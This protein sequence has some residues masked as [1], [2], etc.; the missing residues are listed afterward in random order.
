MCSA[1]DDACTSIIYFLHVATHSSPIHRSVIC[2]YCRSTGTLALV[3]PNHASLYT[4]DTKLSGYL[5]HLGHIML[6]SR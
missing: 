2:R 3:C 6:I 5:D 1:E 4:K